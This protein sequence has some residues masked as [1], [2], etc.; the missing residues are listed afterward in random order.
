MACEFATVSVHT[1]P[2][3]STHVWVSFAG[4]S[5]LMIRKTS[6]RNSA[7]NTRTVTV[8]RSVPMSFQVPR[9]Q[10]T[11]H[12]IDSYPDYTLW[13][14]ARLLITC[15]DVDCFGRLILPWLLLSNLTSTNIQISSGTVSIKNS[16]SK[17]DETKPLRLASRARLYRLRPPKTLTS[18]LMASRSISLQ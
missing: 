13:K 9:L 7:S 1:I 16:I 11:T 5:I 4:F 6:S 10:P 15:I 14:A 2:A 17:K 12:F 8:S 3:Y 18:P